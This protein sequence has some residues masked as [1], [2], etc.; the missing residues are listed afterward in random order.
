MREATHTSVKQ[1]GDQHKRKDT[2]NVQ[3]PVFLSF[4]EFILFRRKKLGLTRKELAERTDRSPEYIKKIEQNQSKPMYILATLANAL[5]LSKEQIHKILSEIE[6]E[7]GVNFAAIFD[8]VNPEP[9]IKLVSKTEPENINFESDSEVFKENNSRIP[10]I[11]ERMLLHLPTSIENREWII[12]DLKEEFDN[13]YKKFGQKI[14]NKWCY[15][16]VIGS[17]WSLL[18]EKLQTRIELSVVGRAA[19]MLRR[20]IS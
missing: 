10:K 13:I 20:F 1:D 18:V 9:D 19:A 4:G 6:R 17:F 5:E 15:Q 8:E 12:G 16:Q 2:I 3:N 14:A 7:G 11:A